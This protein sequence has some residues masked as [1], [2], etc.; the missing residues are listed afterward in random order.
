MYLQDYYLFKGR[1]FLNDKIK[2][3]EKNKPFYILEKISI[4]TKILVYIDNLGMTVAFL[5]LCFLGFKITIIKEKVIT[6]VLRKSNNFEF[7]LYY[8]LWMLP[9]KDTNKIKK[10][11]NLT[12]CNKIYYNFKDF[13]FFLE[14]GRLVVLNSKCTSAVHQLNSTLIIKGQFSSILHKESFSRFLK[15]PIFIR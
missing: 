1:Y 8:I 2:S 11:S 9:L 7:I 10:L 4:R 13:P 15:L 12:N 6:S 14:M 5:L 3:I